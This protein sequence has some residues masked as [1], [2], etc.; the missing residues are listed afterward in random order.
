MHPSRAAAKVAQAQEQQAERLEKLER[1]IA[2]IHAVIVAPASKVDE[3][4]A[5]KPAA[6]K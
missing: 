6:K 1:L 3:K 5:D 2:E 4:P